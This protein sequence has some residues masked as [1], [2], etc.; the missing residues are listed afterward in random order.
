MKHSDESAL[1]AS[2]I[3][4]DRMTQKECAA[5]FGVTPRTLRDWEEQAHHCKIKAAPLAPFPRSKDGTYHLRG[6]TCWMIL[7][8]LGRK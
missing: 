8:G 2:E 5:V 7:T 4:Y 6:M 1:A 3:D